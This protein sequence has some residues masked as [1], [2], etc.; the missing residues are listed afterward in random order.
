MDAWGVIEVLFGVSTPGP[1]RA[2]KGQNPRLKKHCHA[3]RGRASHHGA[4]C[5]ANDTSLKQG[6]FHPEVVVAKAH[7]GQRY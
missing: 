3:N 7:C 2:T 1:C 5:I 6:A 4:P